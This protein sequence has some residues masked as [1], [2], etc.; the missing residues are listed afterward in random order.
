[1][2]RS[3]LP[4]RCEAGQCGR[5]LSRGDS[6]SPQ[7]SQLTQCSQ[8]IARPQCGWCSSRGGNG[9][10]HCLQGGLDGENN[11]KFMVLK[12]LSILACY[13]WIVLL[14]ISIPL[15]LSLSPPPQVWVRV[16][17]LWQ[18]A[19]GLF[20]IVQRRMNAPTV[21]TTVTA[22][23]TATI[24]HKDTTAPANRVTYLAGNIRG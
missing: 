1:M 2:S 22:L 19:A 20:S 15:C 8:C 16:S 7:C 4:L 24:C 18:T 9:A 21:I 14:F 5:L 13:E 11:V 10:G 3:F 23:R 17:A 6:C 12:K